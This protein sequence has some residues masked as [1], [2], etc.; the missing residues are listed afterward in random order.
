ML[1]AH[2]TYYT[3]PLQLALSEADVRKELAK[4]EEARLANG[5]IALHETLPS[6]FLSLGMELEEMQ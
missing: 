4:E 6:A 5:E 3:N 1:N 2:T